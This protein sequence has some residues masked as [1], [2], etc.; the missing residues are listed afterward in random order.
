MDTEKILA[1]C[2]AIKDCSLIDVWEQE[3]HIE[4]SQLDE[5]K[6][7]FAHNSYQRMWRAALLFSLIALRKVAEFAENRGRKPDDLRL[8][9][10]GLHLHTLTGQSKLLDNALKTKIDKAVA[11]LTS[12]ATLPVCRS[13]TEPALR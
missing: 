1:V 3:F 9:Q 11:H 13:E 6:A 2:V 4:L 5:T 7:V 12:S 8:D 10:F